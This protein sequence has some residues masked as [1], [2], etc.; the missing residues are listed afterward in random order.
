MASYSSGI[1]EIEESSGVALVRESA[2]AGVVVMKPPDGGK[3]TRLV[4]RTP[5]EMSSQHLRARLAAHNLYQSSDA[6]DCLVWRWLK[7]RGVDY[8]AVLNIV[9]P[10]CRASVVFSDDGLFRY[11]SLGET[12]F[13]QVVVDEDDET[14]LDVLAWSPYEPDRFGTQ[15]GQ[16]GLLGSGNILNPASF[17]AGPC[18]LWWDALTWLQAGCQGAVVLDAKLAR[19]VL[20]RAPGPLAAEDADHARDLVSSGA[21][22]IKALL[23]ARWESSMTANVAYVPAEQVISRTSYRNGFM[24]TSGIR[25]ADAATYGVSAGSLSGGRVRSRKG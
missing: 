1:D 21:V 6:T 24:P 12:G 19:P 4:I 16:A 15:L 13:L 18:R 11:E 10:I 5:P 3:P 8:D 17:C 14:P 7:A 25:A 9:G 2:T 22:N 20:A 23:V